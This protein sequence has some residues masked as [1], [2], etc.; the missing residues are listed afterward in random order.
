MIK[1]YRLKRKGVINS[2][3]QLVSITGEKGCYSLKDDITNH[4]SK[5]HDLCEFDHLKAK[6]VFIDNLGKKFTG[7]NN[8]SLEKRAMMAAFIAFYCDNH[9]KEKSLNLLK[10]TKIPM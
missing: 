6:G 7:V 9:G 8:L 1:A 2:N 5:I 10:I 4:I 3:A